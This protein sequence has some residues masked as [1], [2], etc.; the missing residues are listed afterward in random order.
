V[1]IV[2]SQQVARS[3]LIHPTIMNTSQSCGLTTPT[4]GTARVIDCE[5]DEAR[6]GSHTVVLHTKHSHILHTFHFGHQL[7]FKLPHAAQKP[8]IIFL[9]AQ[10]REF[11][12]DK[13]HGRKKRKI[14][15]LTR[16]LLKD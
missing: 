9:P 5:T 12:S 16:I 4:K 15:L 7:V 6:R 3:S 11:S 8:P 13:S 2:F 1:A 14:I 10:F